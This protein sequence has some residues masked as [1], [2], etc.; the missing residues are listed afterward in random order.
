MPAA[1]ADS[2]HISTSTRTVIDTIIS[3]FEQET[4]NAA[5]VQTKVLTEILRHN[6]QT[7]YLHEVCGLD[8]RTD[9]HSF[10]QRVP[11]V[12]HSDL[13]PYIDRI[14][15]GDRT[16]VLT[17]EPIKTLSLSSGTTS[18][19][20][21]KY[22]VLY[23][24]ILE[25]SGRLGRIA[26][27]YRS[28]A[29]PT[30][31]GGMFLELVFSGKLST[32]KGGHAVATGTTHLF[33]SKEFKQK[34]KLASVRTCSPEEVVR[35]SDNRQAMY[36]HLLCA[37]LCWEELE[38][39]T[40]T[41]AYTFV[42]AFR[43]FELQW[44]NLCEDIRRGELNSWITDPDLRAAMSKLMPMPDPERADTIAAKC[45][46]LEGWADV[47]PQIWPN[48]KY[49]YSIMT[50]SMEPYLNRL[51]HYAGA[52]PLVSADYGATES[53]VG[54]NANPKAEP[55]DVTFTVVP[56][57]AFFE[58]LPLPSR[59][60]FSNIQQEVDSEKE[61]NL[62]GL[63]E[64]EVGREYEVVLTTYGGLYR[65]RLGDVVR[66]TSF[67]NASPQLAYVCR[68]N[69][70]LNV[71]ID[72]NTEKDLQ[73]AVN[74]AL[75]KLKRHDANAELVDFT[76]FADLSS[77]PGHYVVFWELSR[78]SNSKVAN[79]DTG[80]PTMN[81]NSNHALI[82]QGCE[83]GALCQESTLRECATAMDHAFLEP[84][85][86]GSRKIKTIGALELCVVEPGTF[87]L[88][89]ERYLKRGSGAITQYKTPRCIAS[90]EVLDI[91]TS[92]VVLSVRSE[93]Y[94]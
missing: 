76:S 80:L 75:E 94:L 79:Q 90:Q 67:F 20:Q 88:L 6:A 45:C 58:F 19:G 84:G 74:E 83:Q 14:A 13:K 7:E 18:D 81:H 12:T 61:P 93:A 17:A 22:L 8:G 27:A 53:W 40:A 37:L 42:E 3:D 56:S 35:H 51:Q 91:L 9:V 89:L 48:C 55:Q 70:L 44:A 86:M 32:T 1:S 77:T 71:H 92:R 52:L 11:V 54:V 69:V 65:Y 59:S 62:V 16:P 66:V 33:R 60:D 64:V 34:Q 82:T 25:A 4:I 10:K 30:R 29:F 50:G 73:I 21:H 23:K 5:A 43:T 72:K 63:T 39:M 85:Y 28:R 78:K 36:C 24:E 41:F 38:F 26:A 31:A 87:R 15:E 68:R 47:I 57:F 46:A 2:S 49:I